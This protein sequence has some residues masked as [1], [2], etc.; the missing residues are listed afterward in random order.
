M[1]DRS[2]QAR[3][4]DSP[5]LTKRVLRSIDA[6]QQAMNAREFE[7]APEIAIVAIRRHNSARAKWH[8]FGSGKFHRELRVVLNGLRDLSNLCLIVTQDGW[9][10]RPRMV[11]EAWDRLHDAEAR[12]NY[13]GLEAEF[14]TSCLA[15]VNE[16]RDAIQSRFGTGLYTSW[17]VTFERT[18]CT[19]CNLD[20]RS[21]EHIPGEWY[22]N[23]VCRIHPV[24]LRTV[25]VALVENP[26]DPRCRIWPWNKRETNP[27]GT[28]VI[29]DIPI[30]RIFDL[31]GPADGGTVVNIDAL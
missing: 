17:E 15:I 4:A 10:A 11:E 31:D 19:I 21:C 5:N 22:E 29:K 9:L 13:S 3:R 6:W 7:R 2:D 1:T 14:R 23:Q 30:F 12:L 18:E 24:D 26:R 8:S 25:A 27:D 20:I 16:A 28:R